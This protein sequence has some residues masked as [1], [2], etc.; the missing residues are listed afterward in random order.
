MSL[1]LWLSAL[2]VGLVAQA[3]VPPEP[4]NDRIVRYDPETTAMGEIQQT[5]EIVIGIP[6]DVLPFGFVDETSGEPRGFLVDLARDVAAALGVEATLV[7]ESSGDLLALIDRGELDIA[8]PASPVTEQRFRERAYTTPYYVAHQRLL[9]PPGS[10]IDRVDDLG[11]VTVCSYA[12]EA[13]G[14]NLTTLNPAVE[15][16]RVTSVDACEVMLQQ[17]RAAAVSAPDLF[18][19][20]LLDTAPADYEIVG[21]QINTEGYSGVVQLGRRGLAGFVN[22]VMSEAEVEGRW[23]EWYERWI[24]PLTGSTEVE[25]PALEAEE[26]AALYP[27]GR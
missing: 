8:F 24:S 23:N 20:S 4:S 27:I 1:R 16:I 9:V 14:V 17:G 18:L 7:A 13:T 3:C 19:I 2:A 10:R 12:D 26:A 21:P 15:V 25:P 11:G 22:S 5:G 6:D